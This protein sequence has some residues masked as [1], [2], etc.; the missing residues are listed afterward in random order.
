MSSIQLSMMTSKLSAVKF[1][2]IAKIADSFI[3][4]SQI[5]LASSSVIPPGVGQTRFGCNGPSG[6]VTLGGGAVSLAVMMRFVS[7]LCS[8]SQ[9]EL[10]TNKMQ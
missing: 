4:A 2:H 6:R 7:V 9:M 8:N 10:L 3:G 5:S 1:S